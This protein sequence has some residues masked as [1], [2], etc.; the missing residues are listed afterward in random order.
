[1]Y[2]K[3][4]IFENYLGKIG[5]NPVAMGAVKAI[6]EALFESIDD[7]LD[8]VGGVDISEVPE[9]PPEDSSVVG[10]DSA[11]RKAEYVP[12]ELDYKL[13]IQ[14]QDALRMAFAW[15]RKE[16]RFD[17]L[18][19]EHG[20]IDPISFMVPSGNG[21]H[22][23][24]GPERV[25]Y[26]IS[27]DGEGNSAKYTYPTA[28]NPVK[29]S[30]D[31]Y[32]RIR[33]Y[34][35]AHG[36]GGV[37][38]LAD[39]P[40]GEIKTLVRGDGLH[41]ADE[42]APNIGVLCS[43]GVN[44]SA[45]VLSTDV[46]DRDIQSDVIVP[47]YEKREK[48]RVEYGVPVE[49]LYV[50]LLREWTDA[51]DR[52]FMDAETGLVYDVTRDSNVES[53]GV[54]DSLVPFAK[55]KKHEG[56]LKLNSKV[57]DWARTQDMFRLLLKPNDAGV[58]KLVYT[59]SIHKVPN[60]GNIEGVSGKCPY[61]YM[62][63][64]N[65]GSYVE[66]NPGFDR[67]QTASFDVGALNLIVSNEYKER[68]LSDASGSNAYGYDEN[69]WVANIDCEL[70]DYGV[71]A[72]KRGVD[73]LIRK[74]YGRNVSGI[75]NYIAGK[76]VITVGGKQDLDGNVSGG[77]DCHPLVLL[78]RTSAGM[79]KP[80]LVAVFDESCCKPGEPLTKI[81][82]L[83]GLRGGTPT[84]H[85]FTTILNHC[86]L[87]KGGDFVVNECVLSNVD[88]SHSEGFVKIG[89]RGSRSGGV[90][91]PM[92][93][94][95]TNTVISV[96]N[97]GADQ[98]LPNNRIAAEVSNRM[99]GVS[100]VNSVV[101]DSFIEN[102]YAEI[103]NCNIKN[104]QMTNSGPKRLRGWTTE[105]AGNVEFKGEN[106]ISISGRA[107]YAKGRERSVVAGARSRVE[108]EDGDVEASFAGNVTLDSTAGMVVC[109]GSSLQDVV[110]NGPC[111]IR[112]CNLTGTTIGVNAE[113]GGS[114][115]MT[116]MNCVDT[117]PGV[118]GSPFVQIE[119][120]IESPTVFGD[121]RKDR[122]HGLIEL[123]GRVYV[124]GGAHVFRSIVSGAAGTSGAYVR[125]N[126]TLRGCTPYSLDQKDSGLL[127]K[128]LHEDDN[129]TGECTD[130]HAVANALQRS[131]NE[132][133]GN[134]RRE[135]PFDK[136]DKFKAGEDVGSLRELTVY[137]SETLIEDFLKLN[138]GCVL[139]DKS[140]FMDIGDDGNIV[141]NGLLKTT[142]W[143]PIGGFFVGAINK[144]QDASGNSVTSYGQMILLKCPNVA[145]D[146]E[147]ILRKKDEFVQNMDF[148]LYAS[149]KI[150]LRQYVDFLESNGYD[151]CFHYVEGNGFGKD[152]V[153]LCL[154]SKK[155]NRT[156]C[157]I[158]MEQMRILAGNTKRV[159]G[160]FLLADTSSP[161]G[162]SDVDG[163]D[164]ITSVYTDNSGAMV[165][166][167]DRGS[168]RY[169]APRVDD[170][171][172]S[173]QCTCEKKW[174]DRDGKTRFSRY[175]ADC[176]ADAMY[177][178][179]YQFMLDTRS[180]ANPA[181][182]AII[183]K[184]VYGNTDG[185]KSRDYLSS[186]VNSINGKAMQ[187]AEAEEGHEDVYIKILK[188]LSLDTGEKVYFLTGK[189]SDGS[190]KSFLAKGKLIRPRSDE[191]LRY[192]DAG[193][194]K[195]SFR[196]IA[197]SP[198]SGRFMVSQKSSVYPVKMR[199]NLKPSAVRMEH[200]LAREASLEDFV[201]LL[202][203]PDPR[204]DG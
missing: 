79:V 4:A 182:L 27:A 158:T 33:E 60:D 39:I 202:G 49:S 43:V 71:Y 200:L 40:F 201:R 95:V 116:D 126:M 38:D 12:G 54:G 10:D 179:G 125:G 188:L 165:V 198:D 144:T 150:T 82:G 181:A 164:S 171:G 58:P 133:G 83:D 53:M 122:T 69:G 105:D 35:D 85:G 45:I 166:E 153:Q 89:A 187:S 68:S 132:F 110:A 65:Y 32:D 97:N 161:S 78:D 8:D 114:F 28:T 63:D 141:P 30:K 62:D 67:S 90:D 177:K 86:D 131:L 15:A 173:I 81:V 94:V 143:D 174:R 151:D 146:H 70:V 178:A 98:A 46:D 184:A 88:I 7:L 22:V 66:S 77:V 96:G 25:L 135:T 130:V 76:N 149:G 180:T 73:A 20:G 91:S 134:A 128:Y 23:F 59:G 168:Y 169:G 102:G 191:R 192:E 113:A 11:Q 108:Y 18:W 163:A 55:K 100:I 13:R 170:V 44:P 104:L 145:L 121:S 115:V 48:L 172:E 93:T 147:A 186:V 140:L 112:T 117:T 109:S 41:R 80:R 194:K 6:N 195:M 75:N 50:A 175:V 3:K 64:D 204:L 29:M 111:N 99:R 118:D 127:S 74:A 137:D 119:H 21:E 199:N 5:M 196:R 47:N 92:K 156:P 157:K 42:P 34:Y 107:K 203:V 9:T 87:G 162:I 139:A 106:L 37:V 142:I 154:I 51:S 185:L 56:S 189:V 193:C 152:F 183:R 124:E 120:G 61:V 52:Y 26:E 160:H 84:I 155:D 24:F 176:G 197:Y 138:P 148:D 57:V 16:P 14:Y 136:Y 190:T 31:V 167:T 36:D 17:L 103:E 72:I 123:S 159:V 129:L 19:N 101:S 1:M 2:D